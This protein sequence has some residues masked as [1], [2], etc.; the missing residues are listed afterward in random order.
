M[1]WQAVRS[2]TQCPGQIGILSVYETLRYFCWDGAR[3]GIYFACSVPPD[4]PGFFSRGYEH[5]LC[6]FCTTSPPAGL[7]C[8]LLCRDPISQAMWNYISTLKSEGTLSQL[9][10]QQLSA[11]LMEEMPVPINKTSL[12]PSVGL[13][14]GHNP[15]N[16]VFWEPLVS[17]W[18][19]Q[20]YISIHK[21]AS[22]FSQVWLQIVKIKL[23]VRV[24]SFQGLLKQSSLEIT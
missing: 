22:D 4:S 14:S 24:Q 16:F 7:L 5:S 23:R 10:V 1:I 15:K 12:A 3:K 19:F 13:Q 11:P 2:G 18:D 20:L 8:A 9:I 21:K 17:S 6:L